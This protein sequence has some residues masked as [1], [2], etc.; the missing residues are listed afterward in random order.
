MAPWHGGCVCAL[1]RGLRG[2]HGKGDTQ[3]AHGVGVVGVRWHGEF[4]TAPDW[5]GMEAAVSWGFQKAHGNG[6]S[7]GLSRVESRDQIGHEFQNSS[8]T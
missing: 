6:S 4:D 5:C 3:H 8:K 1:T 7:R 2:A